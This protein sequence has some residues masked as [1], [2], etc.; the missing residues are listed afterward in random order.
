MALLLATA[1]PG[2]APGYRL[3]SDVLHIFPLSP[4][5]GGYLGHVLLLADHGSI[6][7]CAELH[8]RFQGSAHIVTTHMPLAKANFQAPS[9]GTGKFALPCTSMAGLLQKAENRVPCASPSLWAWRRGG[10]DWR[11]R[12]G[13]DQ[14]GM[15]CGF[16]PKCPAKLLDGFTLRSNT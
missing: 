7:G 9:P 15:G 16:Y 5:T 10:W 11:N 12:L 3:D 14:R 2:V 1:N 6:K 4:W 13:Q 8:P